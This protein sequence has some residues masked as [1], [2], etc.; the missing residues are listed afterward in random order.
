MCLCSCV[1]ETACQYVSM[2]RLEQPSMVK[3][4]KVILT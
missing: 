1:E 4:K 2:S 3:E